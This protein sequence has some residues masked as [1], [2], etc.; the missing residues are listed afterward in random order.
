MILWNN[1]DLFAKF[2]NPNHKFIKNGVIVTIFE[3]NVA[4]TLK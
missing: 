2:R 3:L 4:V 1:S